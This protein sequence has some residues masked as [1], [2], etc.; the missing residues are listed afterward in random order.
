MKSTKFP[1]LSGI[2]VLD[3]QLRS[4]FLFL[5]HILFH[6]SMEFGTLLAPATPGG[7]SL[8]TKNLPFFKGDR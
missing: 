7:L 5:L 4:F 1:S 6:I 2:D 8:N 3:L